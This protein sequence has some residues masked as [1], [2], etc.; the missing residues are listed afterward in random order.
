MAIKSFSPRTPSQRGLLQIDRSALYKGRP[1]KPLTSKLNNAAGRNNTGRITVRHRGGGHK[2]K[3]RIIDFKR[4][5]DGRYQVERIEHDPNRSSFIALVK[6]LETASYS[7]IISPD[8]IKVGDILSNGDVCENRNGN[9]MLVQNIPIGTS[10]H[11]IELTPGK[12]AQICR[13]AGAY[14]KLMSRFNSFVQVR[15]VSGE[16]R[17]VPFGCRATIGSVSNSENKNASI[18]KAGRSRWLRKRPSVRGVAMNPVDHP[19]GGGE[20]KTSGGRHPVNPNGKLAKGKKT[21]S[22]KRTSKFI[23]KKRGR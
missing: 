20:G 17:L 22:N 21:R 5:L 12:G 14:G 18:G 2:R 16:V 9:C 11:N 6:N 23:I 19:H 8:S 10:I 3:Y 1:Y 7:Y 15:L 13:S 4:H